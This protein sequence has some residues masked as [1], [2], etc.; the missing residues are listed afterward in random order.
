MMKPNLLYIFTDQ[1]RLDTMACYGNDRI[2]SP[3]LDALANE[4]F[5][6]Q[7]P[8]V[9]QPVCSPSRATMLCG[10][11]P[12]TAKV[13]ACNVPLPGHVQTIAE[14]VSGD[15]QSA[16]IGKW[17]LGDEI[18]PQHGFTE[19]IA[20]EDA[21]RQFFSS[22][23]KHQHRSDYHHF[24][25]GQGV[26]P[27]SMSLGQPIFSRYLQASQPEV[28]TKASYQGDRA[29][30]FIRQSGEQPFLLVVSYLEPHPPHT[31]PL[32]SYYDPWNL[33]TGPNFRL[34]P[35]AN[36]SLLNRVLSA[37]YM[38]S[39]E[40][41][42]DLRTE[43]GW[44][45]VR[46]RY[47]G[48]VT[49]M[50]RSV[51]QILQALEE[52]GKADETIVVFTSD[53]GEM[54]G[55]H[56]ILGKTVLYEESVKVPLLI[57]VPWLGRQQRRIEGNLSQVDLVPTLLDLMG[58]AIPDHLQGQ[59]RLEV[60]NGQS[61]LSH[62]DVFIQWNRSDGHPRPGEGGVNP[63]MSTPWRSIVSA[64]RWK[65]NLSAHDQCELYDLNADPYEIQNLFDSLEQRNRVRDLTSRIRAWQIDT[66]DTT[67]L[68][69]IG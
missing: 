20:T 60:L 61:T 56:G 45:R 22:P 18:F 13:P 15:Y 63:A 33:P 44:R 25:I 62:N 16:Y 41:G 69:G 43:E 8:Y 4:S 58:Q 38:E 28:L 29:T 54:L 53:H 34:K 66:G 2:E 64:D 27:D 3:A 52:S 10:L 50:D 37:Y 17:H 1:Q 49:L 24:L 65:L 14:M 55:D 31:G 57:R 68:P 47:W 5:V 32:N 42:Y 39:Q 7:H 9:S 51:A 30:R 19:W 36:A 35:P 46:G 26:R 48:N 6:F 21:Y 12:H 23:E 40:E 67:T 11:Y 59:S